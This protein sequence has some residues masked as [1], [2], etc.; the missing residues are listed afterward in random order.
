M[1]IL[2]YF[3]DLFYVNVLRS[4]SVLERDNFFF[5]RFINY[6]LS[7]VEFWMRFDFL[8]KFQRYDKC[9]EDNSNIFFKLQLKTGILM[10][11]Y[12][13]KCIITLIFIYFKRN[14]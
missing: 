9:T 2:T 11:N 7:S 12:V 5:N 1:W 8:I 3:I 13:E 4:I 6:N 14:Y 10:E